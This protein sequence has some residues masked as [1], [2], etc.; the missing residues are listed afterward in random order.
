[1]KKGI[2]LALLILIVN[3]LNA[4]IIDKGE[5]IGDR[6]FNDSYDINID[7]SESNQTIVFV[8]TIPKNK[9]AHSQVE[10]SHE[11]SQKN[12][13]LLVY[14]KDSLTDENE[15]SLSVFYFRN[16]NLFERLKRLE[17]KV[18]HLTFDISKS[19]LISINKIN[20]SKNNSYW[21]ATS[22]YLIDNNIYIVT[23]Y[24]KRVKKGVKIFMYKYSK[25][26]TSFYSEISKI[27]SI[28]GNVPIGNFQE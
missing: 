19:E 26:K 11:L 20:C 23:I 3:I 8:S 27:A 14:I 1:M 10:D 9:F 16:R 12:F 25:E 4:Q 24:A 21:R 15:F 2:T 13:R 22:E 5:F 17:K 28:C 7:L 6:Y 18:K